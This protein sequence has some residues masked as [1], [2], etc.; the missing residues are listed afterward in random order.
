MSLIGPRPVPFDFLACDEQEIKNY[1]M[2]HRIRPGIMGLAQVRQGYTTTVA[3][4]R[5]KLKYIYIKSVSLKMDL[6]ILFYSMKAIR[7]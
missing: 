1:Q 3:E 4:E 2:R 5:R 6:A 7:K